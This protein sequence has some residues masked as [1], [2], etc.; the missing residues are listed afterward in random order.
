MFK[1]KQMSNI[2]TV[3][4]LLVASANLIKC[5]HVLKHNSIR[6]VFDT[7]QAQGNAPEL[8]CQLVFGLLDEW[9]I[10]HMQMPYTPLDDSGSPCARKV[11]KPA[12]LVI[13]LGNIHK[14]L[15]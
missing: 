11:L 13:M 8:L 2:T 10:Y 1:V 9:C 15:G 4:Q 7:L 6:S 12:Q 14:V 3:K 5:G